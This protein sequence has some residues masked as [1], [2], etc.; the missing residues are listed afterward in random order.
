MI[1]YD[2]L[3]RDRVSSNQSVLVD[4]YREFK[5]LHQYT[6]IE[7]HSVIESEEGVI[8]IET[9]VLKGL[10]L[11]FGFFLKIDPALLSERRRMDLTKKRRVA[12]ASELNLLQERAIEIC[13]VALGDKLKIVRG[14]FAFHEV[15]EALSFG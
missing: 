1:Q 5:A 2:E 4:A 8:E 6:M 15:K 7:L 3:G 11:D 13:Q 10:E 12:S 14:E 9:E